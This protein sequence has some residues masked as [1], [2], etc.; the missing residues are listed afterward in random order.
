MRNQRAGPVK[1]DRTRLD[2]MHESGGDALMP[3]ALSSG[4][5]LLSLDIY[6]LLSSVFR[7]LI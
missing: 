4:V 6:Y 7:F 3:S 5:L 2:A 1:P